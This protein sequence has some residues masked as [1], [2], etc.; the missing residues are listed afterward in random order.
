MNFKFIR[1]TNFTRTYRLYKLSQKGKEFVN[2]SQEILAVSPFVNPFE[3][4][5]NAT[6]NNKQPGMR[7]KQR[8]PYD[9]IN[10]GHV[11]KQRQVGGYNETR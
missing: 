6:N 3:I 1:A 5:R 9:S 7:K 11:E 2:N 4:K 8:V 10:Q